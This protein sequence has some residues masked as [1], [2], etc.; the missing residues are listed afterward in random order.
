MAAEEPQQQPEPLGGDTDGKRGP[1]SR[2]AP[3][4]RWALEKGKGGKRRP[5]FLSPWQPPLPVWSP[6]SRH[7]D[8]PSR[9]THLGSSTPPFLLR[10]LADA[11][12]GAASSR[13][14]SPGPQGPAMLHAPPL[15]HRRAQARPEAKGQVR[16]SQGQAPPPPPIVPLNFILI[17]ILL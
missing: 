6:L 15:A 17:V 8:G 12:R 4:P 16:S 2:G 11:W 5:R 13:P 9:S 1:L 14:R 7:G 10:P 3:K